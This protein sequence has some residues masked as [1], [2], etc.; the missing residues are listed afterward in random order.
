MIEDS[1]TFTT[2][3]L[4]SYS[5]IDIFD[6]LLG[7]KRLPIEKDEI[8]EITAIGAS[9][10]ERAD[11]VGVQIHREDKWVFSFPDGSYKGFRLGS[12]DNPHVFDN[13]I[14]IDGKNY[15]CWGMDVTV[16]EL[17]EN[18]RQ[19]SVSKRSLVKVIVEYKRYRLNKH[20]RN[21][22]YYDKIAKE[23]NLV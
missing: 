2:N 20:T 11:L 17:P 1:L 18:E 22:K 7:R 15:S 6:A 12:Y 13:P 8:I 4:E 9:F 14:K 5:R 10:K 16:N 23:V 19:K 21:D 3:D